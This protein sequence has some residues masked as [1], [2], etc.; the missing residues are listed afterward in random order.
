MNKTQLTVSR[1]LGGVIRAFCREYGVDVVEE[2]IRGIGTRP[3]FWMNARSII[4]KPIPKVK[5]RDYYLD[6]NGEQID[7]HNPPHVGPEKD[8]D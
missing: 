6:E 2:F 5:M 7:P 4:D 3:Q 1:L 8:N